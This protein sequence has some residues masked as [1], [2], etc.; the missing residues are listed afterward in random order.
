MSLLNSKYAA[1]L[2][3]ALQKA[4]SNRHPENQETRGQDLQFF[5]PIAVVRFATAHFFCGIHN[6][7][8][9]RFNIAAAD[10]QPP[11]ICFFLQNERT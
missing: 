1:F 6:T 5:H 10:D 7:D 11:F 3:A 2:L 4:F 9:A 8:S